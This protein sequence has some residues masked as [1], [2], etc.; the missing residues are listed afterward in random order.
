M[1]A[2]LYFLPGLTRAQI[3]PQGKLVRAIIHD[4]GLGEIFADVAGGDDLALCDVNAGP[5]KGHGCVLVALPNDRS[6]YFSSGYHPD[7]QVWTPAG[8][9][10]GFWIGAEPAQPPSP[11]DLERKKVHRGYTIEL[12][13]GA[14]WTIPIVRRPDAV[15]RTFALQSTELPRDFLIGAEGQVDQRIQKAY[16]AAWEATGEVCEFF[17]SEE[18]VAREV[19]A[20]DIPWAIGHCLRLLSLN[21]RIGPNEQNL[22][23][24]INSENWM[25]VLACAVDQPRCLTLIEEFNAAEQKKS[26]PPAPRG[27]SSSL[28][29]AGA[30]PSIGPAA[31]NCS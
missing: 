14:R 4:R 1:A 22:L 11:A 18:G 21:Y 13:D 6:R 19:V 24:L 17:F 30:D 16:E 28:G 26:D 25:T 8:D 2:P 15:C 9:G 23:R 12:G 5:N 31:A 3:C 29:D 7:R 20:N 10:Q 27:A